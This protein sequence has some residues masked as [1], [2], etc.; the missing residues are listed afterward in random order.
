MDGSAREFVAA[1]QQAGIQTL[2]GA[3]IEPLVVRAPVQLEDGIARIAALPYAGGLKITY[4]LDYPGQPLAQGSYEV[5]L[6]EDSLRHGD[7]ARAHVRP[8]EGR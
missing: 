4:R 3:G 6:N 1:I 8:Q 7:R 5:E 2:D